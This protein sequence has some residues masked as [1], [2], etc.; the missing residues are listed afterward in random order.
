MSELEQRHVRRLGRSRLPDLRFLH[1]CVAYGTCEDHDVLGCVGAHCA[2]CGKALRA[3]DPV[4]PV[5]RKDYVSDPVLRREW[6][7]VLRRLRSAFQLTMFGYSGPA[8]DAEARRL[9]RLGWAPDNRQTDHLE[10]VDLLDQ[11]ALERR[12]QAF[13]PFSHLMAHSE[14]G[15]CSIAGWPRARTSGRVRRHFTARQPS[16]SGHVE[17][18]PWR[19]LRTGTRRSANSNNRR[20]GRRETVSRWP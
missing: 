6:D 5:E 12:W 2:V 16:E 7:V 10:V 3:M 9:L 18:A 4:Y 19:R 13:I 14:W 17:P 20:Q 1:G 11:A 8:T 15:Q